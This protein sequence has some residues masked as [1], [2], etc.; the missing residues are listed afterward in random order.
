MPT[1]RFQPLKNLEDALRML[2]AA[3]PDSYS[4]ESK[5]RGT[6]SV[7]VQVGETVGVAVDSSQARAITY[8]VARAVG[9]EPECRNFAK[10]GVDER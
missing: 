4:I 2:N 3:K 9:L 6:C 7:R 1:W 10:T 8:A 5:R